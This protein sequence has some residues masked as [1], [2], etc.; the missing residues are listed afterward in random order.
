MKY[1]KILCNFILRLS[2]LLPLTYPLAY[3]QYISQSSK[4]TVT[5]Q[6]LVLK[7]KHGKASVMTF[8]PKLTCPAS[9]LG[10][11]IM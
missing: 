2:E 5:L 9:T 7:I 11:M 8:F 10:I 1:M 6:P 3:T 4:V